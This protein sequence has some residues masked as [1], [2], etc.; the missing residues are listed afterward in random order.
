MSCSQGSSAYREED[1][2]CAPT[3]LAH[4]STSRSKPCASA[5]HDERI[6]RA[7]CTPLFLRRA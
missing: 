5:L 7:L 1:P 2:I 3:P 4:A 6:Q